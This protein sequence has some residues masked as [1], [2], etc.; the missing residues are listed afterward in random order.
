MENITMVPFTEEDIPELTQIMKRSFDEDSMLH[1]GEK[2]GP[3]GYDN[4]EFLRQW[5]L[6]KDSTQ[7]KVLLGEKM[8]GSV[9]LWIN[10][11]TQ[12]HFLGTIFLDVNQQNTGLG[13]R[14]WKMVEQM[15]PDTKVWRTETPGFSRR[16]HNFYVNKCGF[17][18]VKIE[19]PRDRM[20]CSYLLEKV[21]KSTRG[22]QP[23]M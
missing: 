10:A 19:N 15:Y 8:I 23:E 11:T 9:I 13:S 17:H 2:G 20:E 16:N 4:G 12:E 1:L 3:E 18:V 14:V 6:H 5:G 21:M 22:R 7:F